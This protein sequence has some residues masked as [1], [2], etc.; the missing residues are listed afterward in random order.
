MSA[1]APVD[2]ESQELLSVL[3]DSVNRAFGQLR[4]SVQ[5][6]LAVLTVSFLRVLGA[7]RSGHGRLS[8][9]SLFR[10]LPPRGTPHSRDKRLHRFL[11]NPRLDPLVVT[12]GLPRLICGRRAR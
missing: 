9:G 8:L 4:R 5:M 7:A 2:F 6:N 11:K 1:A 3:E 12:D 10:V